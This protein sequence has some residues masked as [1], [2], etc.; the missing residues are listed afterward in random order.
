MHEHCQPAPPNQSLAI[1]MSS[2]HSKIS[3]TTK[4]LRPESSPDGDS[5]TFLV[6]P[7]SA[8]DKLPARGMNSVE[9]TFNGCPFQATL[10]PDGQSSHWLTVSKQLSESAGADAGDL[11]TL[12]IMPV[13]EEPEPTVPVDLQQALNC[14]PKVME[15]WADI[16]PIARRDWIHWIRSAKR[17]E[18][19]TRRINN[20]CEML[21][22]GKR[23]ACCFDRSGIYSKGMSAP[24]AAQ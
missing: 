5:W 22:A 19:R 24:K 2:A 23:R 3:F 14:T 21:L 1:I 11:V 18:T 15:L 17:A 10:E 20:T 12:E 8:S 16:T 7:K 9:G 13:T 4:L 6:L